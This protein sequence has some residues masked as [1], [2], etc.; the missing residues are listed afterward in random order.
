MGVG[1]QRR[2]RD[3]LSKGG[4]RLN[5][6][7]LVIPRVFVLILNP[8]GS[9]SRVCRRTWRRGELLGAQFITAKQLRDSVREPVPADVSKAAQRKSPAAEGA[10]R[11]ASFGRW[12]RLVRRRRDR[13]SRLARHHPT[14]WPS[15]VLSCFAPA[16]SLSHLRNLHS[17]RKFT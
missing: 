14:L 7:A 13:T 1:R 5:V 9:V 12:Q 8:S 16:C 3:V 4:V 6:G 17:P 15:Q 11:G 10:A 2:R